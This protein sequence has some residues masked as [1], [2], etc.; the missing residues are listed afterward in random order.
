MATARGSSSPVTDLPEEKTLDRLRKRCENCANASNADK[1]LELHK[2]IYA[3]LFEQRTNLNPEH[4]PVTKI[5]EF[6]FSINFG[7]PREFNEIFI[8]V[9]EEE[10][11]KYAAG[12][13]K[14]LRLIDFKNICDDFG[15]NAKDSLYSH[16]LKKRQ[17]RLY[18][19][20]NQYYLETSTA[21]TDEK[22]V[23]NNKLLIENFKTRFDLLDLDLGKHLSGAM[24][25][26]LR[27][28]IQRTVE[29]P[30][31][32]EQTALSHRKN[33]LFSSRKSK[34][35]AA[36]NTM[37]QKLNEL[38]QKNGSLT[39][40]D[41]DPTIKIIE[42]YR[43]ALIKNKSTRTLPIL[44]AHLFPIFMP[45][46]EHRNLTLA[47][48]NDYHDSL[49]EYMVHS[50]NPTIP[51]TRLLPRTAPIPAATNDNPQLM[52]LNTCINEILIGCLAFAAKNSDYNGIFLRAPDS[53]RLRGRNGFLLFAAI[54]LPLAEAA[55]NALIAIRDNKAISQKDKLMLDPLQ[56]NQALSMPSIDIQSK[57]DAVIA[58]TNC[59]RIQLSIKRS[60]RY[61]DKFDEYFI[62]EMWEEIVSQTPEKTMNNLDSANEEIVQLADKEM[63]GIYK[64]NFITYL[65][66]HITQKV[67]SS[68]PKPSEHVAP[69]IATAYSLN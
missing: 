4:N 6:I 22:Q 61:L 65:K 40:H 47:E 13:Q 50:F 43:K 41:L 7:S 36:T 39:H 57:I 15:S 56:K 55:C 54:H 16:A 64:T 1:M 28:F 2:I 20:F 18:V 35:A 29:Y 12:Q 25:E 52:R 23:E 60:E 66:T 24:P 34:N 67:E 33:R 45:H 51:V 31:F 59:Y 46:V 42:E 26:K 69:V 44:D 53:E 63:R 30:Y 38:L 37:Q 17:E 27:S 3:E 58:V 8:T 10:F 21:P 19:E 48:R 9:F 49:I 5:K 32:A 68:Q 14:V 62:Y 11:E